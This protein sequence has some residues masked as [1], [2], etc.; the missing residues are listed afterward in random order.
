MQPRNSKGQFM[1]KTTGN[2]DRFSVSQFNADP[3]EGKTTVVLTDGDGG[4][5]ALYARQI[6]GEGTPKDIIKQTAIAA[7]DDA[8]AAIERL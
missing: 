2:A 8:K 6:G 1:S 3:L 7:L 4:S 5:L